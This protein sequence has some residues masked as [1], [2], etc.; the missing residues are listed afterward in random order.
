M[1]GDPREY[2]QL[3]IHIYLC[4]GVSKKS[5]CLVMKLQNQHVPFVLVLK[6]PLE[7]RIFQ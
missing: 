1:R 4:G 3:T 6:S 7:V 5:F 2:S